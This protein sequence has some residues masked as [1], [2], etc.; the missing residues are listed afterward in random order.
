MIS[1]SSGY[2][3]SSKPSPVVTGCA[4]PNASSYL[5]SMCVCVCVFNSSV[6][7][8]EC[9]V[10]TS[11]ARTL[12]T[13]NSL[14]K[15]HNQRT[16]QSLLRPD[17]NNYRDNHQSFLDL[18]GVVIRSNILGLR[19]S[20]MARQDLLRCRTCVRVCGVR[21]CVVFECVVFESAFRLVW[22][23]DTVKEVLSPITPTYGPQILNGMKTSE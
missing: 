16:C 23:S 17:P 5:C 9:V 22:E 18:P 15:N 6:V 3:A 1:K 12:R 19:S 8:Y 7:R 14:L 4:T 2:R 10:G 20:T 21:E 13:C 11:R